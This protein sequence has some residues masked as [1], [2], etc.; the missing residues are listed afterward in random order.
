MLCV[1]YNKY[2]FLARNS[3]FPEEISGC[4]CCVCFVLMELPPGS[5]W[6]LCK[7]QELSCLLSLCPPELPKSVSSSEKVLH[8]DDLLGAGLFPLLPL[9]FDLFPWGFGLFKPWQ[10][11]GWVEVNRRLSLFQ[12]KSK[13]L[14]L[15]VKLNPTFKVDELYWRVDLGVAVRS[16]WISLFPPVSAAG[17]KPLDVLLFP[18]DFRL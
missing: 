7:E 3:F 2:T 4:F 13:F 5:V 18:L 6:G 16:L 9:L 8:R 10:S 1:S 15:T 12:L 17:I 11:E 14:G